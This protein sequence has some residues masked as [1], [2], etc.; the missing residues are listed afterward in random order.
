MAG[1]EPAQ[2]RRS[3]WLKTLH[4]W[5]WVSAAVCL[6]A[7][8]GFSVTG[9]TL[10]HAGQIQTKPIVLLREAQMPAA[11]LR[12][13]AGRPGKD[14]ASLPD[15]VVE[16]LDGQ[17][18]LNLRGRGP[19]WSDGELYVSL[20]RPGGDAWLSIELD[21]GKT[22]YETT[23]RGWIAYFNDLHKARNTGALWGWF[24]DLFALACLVFSLTGLFLLHLH[25]R[26]R[27]MTWPLVALGFL[28]PFVIAII[29]IH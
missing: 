11:L 25:G 1:K 23:D 17:W 18:Q 5:H 3:Y 29:F 27:A 19:E 21:T 9:F 14:S 24:V 6:I 13:L 12:Q 20:P 7:M 28:L 10:N 4:Q 22:L 16:W 15:P 26:Q 2:K 8:I